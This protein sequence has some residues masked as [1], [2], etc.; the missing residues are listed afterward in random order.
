MNASRFPTLVIAMTIAVA[1]AQSFTAC[2]PKSSP[3]QSVCP[4]S[5]K[6]A[7]KLQFA[8]PTSPQSFGI[9]NH[10]KAGAEFIAVIHDVCPRPGEITSQVN[11]RHEGV[12]ASGVRSYLWTLPRDMSESELKSLADGDSCVRMLTEAKTDRLN[13]EAE[14]QPDMLPNDPAVGLQKDLPVIGA[15]AAYDI[16]YNAKTGIKRNIVIAVVDTGVRLDHEDLRQSVWVNSR[17]IAGNG[18]DDD[19]NGYIDDVYGYNFASHIA[20]PMP[21]KS[22]ANGA[23]QWAHGTKVAGLAAATA[24]NGKG[25]IGVAGFNAKIMALNNMG[26]SDAMSQADTANAIRYAADNGADVI[27]MSLGGNN[28][29]TRDYENAIRYAIAK[30]V[31]VLAAAGNESM[32]IGSS[33]SAAGLSPGIPGL[34]SIGN[35]QAATLLK[36]PLSNYSTTYVKL[37]APGTYSTYELL[38]TTS[39]E[40]TSSY[41]YF[42]GTSAATPVASGA[43]AL[44]IGLIKSRGYRYSPGD[45]EKLLLDSAKKLNSLKAYFRNGNA[46]DLAALARLVDS[47]YPARS[48]SGGASGGVSG[49]VIPEPSDSG[50][51]NTGLCTGA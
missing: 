20:N 3:S 21:Q 35:F 47:R 43:A 9:E 12:T 37:G 8:S 44:A 41:G 5:G 11:N 30:G 2:A 24:G 14:N 33:Y 6:S 1:I 36:A 10:F 48:G 7:A 19:H 18:I 22:A 38:Y 32:Q 28:G 46:L 26:T 17:E 39:P 50:G 23:W 15:S 27:N 13:Q 51:A 49:D 42:S 34:I 40:T 4:D 45:I 29:V 31:V 16:F 25:I